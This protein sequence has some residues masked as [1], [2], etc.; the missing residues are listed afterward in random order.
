MRTLAMPLSIC[1]L[2]AAR[3]SESGRFAEPSGGVNR[4]EMLG[5]RL[6]CAC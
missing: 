5:K 2:R 6:N 3:S 4:L 1:L